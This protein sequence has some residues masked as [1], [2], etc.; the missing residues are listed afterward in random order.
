MT[1]REE[2]HAYLPLTET[3]FFI[4]LSLS[5]F[6]KHGYAVAKDV[7]LL[8][9]SRVVLST[10]TLYTALK[11]LLED[12]WI[13]RAGEEPDPDE[14]GRPRKVYALTGLGRRILAA[15]TRR[16]QSL[17]AAAQLRSTGEEI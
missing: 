5:P 14:T 3:T 2:I 11:R 1:G 12:G 17:V 8:S 9:N 4:L 16:L 15:E 10:S 7:Q 6:P 13:E